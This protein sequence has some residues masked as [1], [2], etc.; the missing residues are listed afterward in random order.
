[1][2]RARQTAELHLNP[3]PNPTCQTRSPLLTRWQASMNPRA[4]HTEAELV[5]PYQKSECHEGEAW[6]ASRPSCF[7]SPSTTPRPPAWR[8]KWSK[9]PPNLG[10]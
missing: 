9:A 4:Y 8:Q 10:T 3:E 6:R 1:M 2:R 7:D 5:L